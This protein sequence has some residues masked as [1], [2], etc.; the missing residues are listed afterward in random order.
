MKV[1]LDTREVEQN[2]AWNTAVQ[3]MGAM[4]AGPQHTYQITSL[5]LSGDDSRQFI[6]ECTQLA[7]GEEILPPHWR[8]RLLTLEPRVEESTAILIVGFKE[9]DRPSGVDCGVCGFSTCEDFYAFDR[10]S[11]KKPLCPVELMSFSSAISRGLQI[12]HQFQVAN[13]LTQS[14]GKAALMLKLIDVDFAV[15]ILLEVGQ[16]VKSP[17]ENRMEIPVDRND[18]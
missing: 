4:L 10:K 9:T 8:K 2:V 5:F 6:K 13:L 16:P 18:C 12:A 11:E 7:H 1:R 15:G 17:K 14:L 3:M